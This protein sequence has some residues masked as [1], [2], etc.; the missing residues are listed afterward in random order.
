MGN[1]W[2]YEKQTKNQKEISDIRGVCKALKKSAG[3]IPLLIVYAPTVPRIDKNRL[4]FSDEETVFAQE[5]EN[6]CLENQIDFLNMESIFCEDFK[7]NR[8]FTS[9]FFNTPPGEGHMN[10]RGHKL[11]ADTIT[12]YLS[13]K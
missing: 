1:H 11:V 7:K 6:S 2:R 5:L 12:K 3:T 10:S 8:K 9:G 4:L 13:G